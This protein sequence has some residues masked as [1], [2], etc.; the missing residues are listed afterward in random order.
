M[1]SFYTSRYLLELTKVYF[2]V[3]K[4]IENNAENRIAQLKH[5]QVL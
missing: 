3:I 1:K 2:Q 4:G 5:R